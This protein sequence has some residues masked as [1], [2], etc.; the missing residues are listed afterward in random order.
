MNILLFL[1]NQHDADVNNL[2]IFFQETTWKEIFKCCPSIIHTAAAN[3][4][5]AGYIFANCIQ[6]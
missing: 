6:L 3:V 1:N 5:S 2:L 4:E